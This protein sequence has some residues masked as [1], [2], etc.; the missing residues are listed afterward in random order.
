M[1]NLTDSSARLELL[2]FYTAMSILWILYIS[3][4]CFEKTINLRIEFPQMGVLDC[5]RKSV[6]LRFV[7]RPT[8][9]NLVFGGVIEFY[10]GNSRC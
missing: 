7:N 1:N 6:Q 10:V 2:V 9:Q 4:L 5:C 8:I 3:L